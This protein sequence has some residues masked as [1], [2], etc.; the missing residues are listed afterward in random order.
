MDGQQERRREAMSTSEAKL[1]LVLAAP[2]NPMAELVR[3][4][5]W[6]SVLSAAGAGALLGKSPESRDVLAKAV[7]IGLKALTRVAKEM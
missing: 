6:V 5:P 7:R 3:E 1:R 4:H 2:D